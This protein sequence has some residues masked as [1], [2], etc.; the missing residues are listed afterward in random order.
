MSRRRDALDHT[1]APV[2][3]GDS[4]DQTRD[5]MALIKDR[6]AAFVDGITTGAI[7]L[8]DL[9][10]RLLLAAADY[11]EEHG[12]TQDVFQ[13]SDGAVCLHGAINRVA[14]SP[15][16]K[17]PA[18][19]RLERYLSVGCKQRRDS[20]TWNDDG[21]R[22]KAQVLAA[23]RGA[24]GDHFP[25]ARRVDMNEGVGLAAATGVSEDAIVQDRRDLLRKAIDLLQINDFGHRRACR[26]GL[27]EIV[28]L[29][30]AAVSQEYA[31]LGQ[32][33]LHDALETLKKLHRQ[34][35]KLRQRRD[36]KNALRYAEFP[37]M[38]TSAFIDGVDRV[39]DRLRLT[40]RHGRIS[41]MRVVRL[42]AKVYMTVLTIALVQSASGK[43]PGRRTRPL[44]DL[45]AILWRIA[46][47][48]QD[49]EWEKA[50][51]TAADTRMS[52]VAPALISARLKACELVQEVIRRAQD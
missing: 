41:S 25:A 34:A 24:A 39:I 38:D 31:T 37:V 7:T 22:T 21:R 20:M 4:P 8:E 5:E 19:D 1:P 50:I 17:Q 46:G 32:R 6:V 11:I 29:T 40:G 45:L 51:R 30:S 23:L 27:E 28:R 13:D 18:I 52:E 48:A 26:W 15:A 10:G 36:I 47:G 33:E 49:E 35:D 9:A 2:R 16:L 43:K 44:H 12:W 14:L 42:P 3:P